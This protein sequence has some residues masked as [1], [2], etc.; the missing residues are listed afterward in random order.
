MGLGQ[1]EKGFLRKQNKSSFNQRRGGTQS[2]WNPLRRNKA[3]C[4]VS[5]KISQAAKARKD[6]ALGYAGVR[7]CVGQTRTLELTR[8]GEDSN[9]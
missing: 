8:N 6:P 9:Q 7:D 2:K 4:W 1:S 5:I 3:I